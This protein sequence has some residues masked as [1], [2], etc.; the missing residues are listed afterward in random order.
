M[1]N[2]GIFKTTIN[3]YYIINWSWIKLHVYYVKFFFNGN[4]STQPIL[5]NTI[6]M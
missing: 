4:Q 2:G 6:K 5:A 1:K 3:R